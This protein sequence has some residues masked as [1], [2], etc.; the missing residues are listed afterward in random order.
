MSI[1]T[2]FLQLPVALLCTAA[3]SH[4]GNR[5]ETASQTTTVSELLIQTI[6][7]YLLPMELI[8]L[9]SL[10]PVLVHRNIRCALHQ[11]CVCFV[12]QY[13]WSW[14]CV[15]LIRLGESRCR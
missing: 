9:P 7:I 1:G 8:I 3:R 11:N 13:G 14:G 2:V 4:L 12:R 10:Q 6:Q 15:C 5:L